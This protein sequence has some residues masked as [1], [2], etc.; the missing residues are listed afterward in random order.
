MQSKNRMLVADLTGKMKHE[1]RLEMNKG[2]SSKL[3]GEKHSRQHQGL[4][5]EVCLMC[6][7]ISKQ[8]GVTGAE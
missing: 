5:M 4:K 2:I 1:R 8:P 3:L 7:K 6:S